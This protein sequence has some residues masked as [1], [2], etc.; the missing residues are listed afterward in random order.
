MI[1][2]RLGVALRDSRVAVVALTGGK[3]A[4]SFVFEAQENPAAVLKAEL[5]SRKVKVRGARVGIARQWATVKTIDLPPAGGGNLAQMVAFELERHLPFSAEDASFDFTPLTSPK[6]T[7]LRVLVVASERRTVERALRL[8]EEAGLRTL[9]LNV[10][11]HDLPALV[12]GLSRRERTAWLHAAGED[13]DLLCFDGRDLVLSR[14]FS[15]IDDEALAAE[16]GKSLALLRWKH[17]HACWVSGSGSARLQSSPALA[18]LL[19]CPVSLPPWSPPVRRAMTAIEE[20]GENNAGLLTLALASALAPRRPTTSLLPEAQRPRPIHWSWLAT[21]ATFAA[22]ALLG[23][24]VIFAQGIQDR[25]YLASVTQATRA[26]NPEVKAVEALS[27]EVER[28]RR[29]LATLRTMEASGI[30]PLPILKEITELLPADAWLTSLTVDSKGMELTGQAAA[31]NQ[32]IPLLENSP[33]LQNVEFASPVT[34]GREKEQFR[35][36]ATLEKPAPQPA[37]PPAVTT[38]PARPAPQPR[39]GK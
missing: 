17:C 29:L 1:G 32:L 12:S 19:H 27:V 37:A 33:L 23:I 9:A 3:V 36:R 2:S 24:G 10:G 13:V 26:L 6:G 4:Q 34:K 30:R 39:K 5:E 20:S 22:T 8:I 14:S 38:A 31:A 11:S 15:G 7:P 16:V 28:K 21:V 25:R 18:A 35:I